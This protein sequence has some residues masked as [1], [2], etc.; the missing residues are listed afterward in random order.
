MKNYHEIKEPSYLKYWD[1]NILHGWTTPQ[2]LPVNDCKV[3]TIVTIE[4]S[5]LNENFIK[6]K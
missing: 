6:M 1:V 3:L 5:Q 4:T 2:K